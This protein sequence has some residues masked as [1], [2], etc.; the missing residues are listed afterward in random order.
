M[1]LNKKYAIIAAVVIVSI[2]IFVSVMKNYNDN[3]AQN[4]LSNIGNNS[5]SSHTPNPGRH[6]SVS[7]NETVSV[8]ANP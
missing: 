2:V 8:R 4:I 6:L 7:I 1:Q 5:S 3:T